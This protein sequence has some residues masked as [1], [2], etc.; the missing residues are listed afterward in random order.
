MEP[1][2]VP[3]D[4]PDRLVSRDKAGVADKAKE[5]KADAVVKAAE[6]AL[7]RLRHRLLRGGP[8][9]RPSWV[10]CRDNPPDAGVAAAPQ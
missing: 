8:M 1:P 9:V 7:R 6:A 5:R 3:Q 10:P 2:P 4:R